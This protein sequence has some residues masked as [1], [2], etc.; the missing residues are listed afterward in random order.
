MFEADGFEFRNG[1]VL[2]R[3][4][5]SAFYR[6]TSVSTSNLWNGQEV[7]KPNRERYNNQK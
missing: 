1:V 3:F 2:Q 5:V 4:S 6:F 7:L